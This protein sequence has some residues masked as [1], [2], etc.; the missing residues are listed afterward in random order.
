M[1]AGS[2]LGLHDVSQSLP[3]FALALLFSLGIMLP[4]LSVWTGILWLEESKHYVVQSIL[5]LS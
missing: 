4:A 2:P 3:D 1:Q 5:F